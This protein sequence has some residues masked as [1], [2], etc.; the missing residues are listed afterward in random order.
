MKK[1]E[2]IETI[3]FWD[4][5]WKTDSDTVNGMKIAFSF[6]RRKL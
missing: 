4:S 2:R 1:N 6:L 3:S 5:L